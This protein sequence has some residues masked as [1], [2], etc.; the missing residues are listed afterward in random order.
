MVSSDLAHEAGRVDLVWAQLWV[1]FALHWA[2][3]HVCW[4]APGMT[5]LILH[6]GNL[7]MLS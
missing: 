1:S 2:Y 5:E 6:Q 3:S 7:D 4:L